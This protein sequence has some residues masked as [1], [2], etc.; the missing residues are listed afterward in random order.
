MKDGMWIL[1]KLQLREMRIRMM[2]Q[3]I[4]QWEKFSL[5]DESSCSKWVNQNTATEDV[6]PEGGKGEGRNKTSRNL[7]AKW[8]AFKFDILCKIRTKI[9]GRLLTNYATIKNVFLLSRNIV[10]VKRKLTNPMNYSR[11]CW[12]L[13]KSIILSWKT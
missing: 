1:K 3:N 2:F 13:M 8:L 4:N 5:F 9:N 7:S 10:A 6:N 11:C 12:V